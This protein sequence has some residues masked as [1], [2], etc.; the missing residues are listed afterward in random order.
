MPVADVHGVAV[1]YEVIGEGQP[2][3]IT[4]GGRFS[5]DYPGVREM[6]SALAA[7]GKQV[8]IWDRPNCG[9]SDVCFTGASESEMQADTL[10]GLLRHLEMTQAIVTGGSGGARVS[11]LTV[12]R[13][14]DVAAGLATWWISGGPYGLLTLG[15]HYCGGSIAA[16][17]HGGMPAVVALAEWQEVLERNTLNKQRFLDQDAAEFIATFEKW[18]LAY[19][20]REDQLIPGLPDTDARRVAVPTL[21]FRSGTTDVHHTRQ[22]S[23]HLA[24]LLPT[25]RLA[26]P[27]WGD[28]EW[29]ERSAA[30]DGLF[31]H[32]P[33]IVPQ[34]VEWASETIG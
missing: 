9:A 7:E 1:A 17:W 2:W 26:E 3:A 4:P 23:E 25:A 32:W 30:P 15:V 18:R 20:P 13:R 6:A 28:N 33:M 29:N 11:L 24:E 10:A 19:C 16:A 14:P 12:A 34:L 5:K 27:P 31:V 21:V 22:T 8:L